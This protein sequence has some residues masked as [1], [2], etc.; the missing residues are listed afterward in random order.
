MRKT[1]SSPE[2][3]YLLPRGKIV[4]PQG[5]NCSPTLQQNLLHRGKFFLRTPTKSPPQGKNCSSA[6]QQNLISRGKIVLPH[7][8]KISSTGEQNLFL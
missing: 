4:P 1:S 6:L 8:N 7:S 5:K 3:K 2:K